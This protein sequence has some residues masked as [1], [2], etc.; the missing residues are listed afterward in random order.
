[1]R[2]QPPR[3]NVNDRSNIRNR[4]WF[5]TAINTSQASEL[6][7]SNAESYRDLTGPD[8]N[9]FR[10]LDSLVQLIGRVFHGELSDA[11]PHDGSAATI[12]SDRTDAVREL[13]PETEEIVKS[14]ALYGLA[15]RSS[16]Q[17]ISS[18]TERILQHA[19]ASTVS[20]SSSPIIKLFEK[21][22]KAQHT[23]IIKQLQA[24][25][26]THSCLLQAQAHADAL[27]G[28]ISK[29]EEMHQL[30]GEVAALYSQCLTIV[31]TWL[32]NE[33]KKAV[34]GGQPDTIL[35]NMVDENPKLS[36]ALEVAAIARTVLLQDYFTLF[37]CTIEPFITACIARGREGIS[38]SVLQHCENAMTSHIIAIH[39]SILGP[40][41]QRHWWQAQ[42]EAV[43]VMQT[44]L[45]ECAFDAAR[46]LSLSAR[47]LRP[48]DGSIDLEPFIETTRTSE[49][50]ESH[51]NLRTTWIDELQSMVPVRCMESLPTSV[52][53]R[54]NAG[55]GLVDTQ[56]WIS[57]MELM[58]HRIGLDRP[59]AG[60]SETESP[61]NEADL[62]APTAFVTLQLSQE[63]A[64]QRNGEASLQVQTSYPSQYLLV[65]SL[66]TIQG[67]FTRY[68]SHVNMAL[69]RRITLFPTQTGVQSGIYITQFWSSPVSYPTT[70][71]APHELESSEQPWFAQPLV[72]F[73][74][75]AVKKL[76]RK[77]MQFSRHLHAP[78]PQQR[79]EVEHLA[80]K[81]LFSH[82]STSAGV[83][84]DT[85]LSMCL[86][87]H[88]FGGIRMVCRGL[89]VWRKLGGFFERTTRRRQQL[90][91]RYGTADLR[92]MLMTGDKEGED[93]ELEEELAGYEELAASSADELQ[94][95]EQSKALMK[96]RKETN[97]LAKSIDITKVTS[98][99]DLR[100]Q[101][102][103]VF[104]A[105]MWENA[106]EV[107]PEFVAKV[108]AR[109]RL[110]RLFEERLLNL[111]SRS[112]NASG[113]EQG[114]NSNLRLTSNTL[115]MAVELLKRA[116]ASPSE[117]KVHATRIG[118]PS[119]IRVTSLADEAL[120]CATFRAACN[121]L[122]DL[123]EDEVK[124]ASEQS[125]R[126]HYS[127]A[128][129]ILGAAEI[130]ALEGR[131]DSAK[132]L[133]LTAAA[134]DRMPTS[135]AK[136]FARRLAEK[137][138]NL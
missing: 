107:T 55:A 138:F 8:A 48:F 75:P 127:A 116:A 29:R 86:T 6:Y 135:Q 59:N 112:D 88:A 99:E 132:S 79:C 24:V 43:Q 77:Q 13:P 16:L 62:Y 121:E 70:P 30:P 123:K 49:S 95:L 9:P 72:P 19:S 93:A 32:A 64:A 26:P 78:T 113:F 52:T 2:I 12:G 102:D 51:E 133:V 104:G 71:A 17:R 131:T 4:G 42:S 34:Q 50:S 10:A 76:S 89:L 91:A 82:S 125:T 31:K 129:F 35:V 128:D 103:E 41:T 60:D 18:L 137:E 124:S 45:L 57:V 47:L 84:L 21:P 136:E 33:T 94:G 37:S 85:F 36:D 39:E 28:M 20:S 117:T 73:Y 96:H 111:A 90:E 15:L 46:L 110:E 130:L 58:R 81:M 14:V 83:L 92:K 106:L 126:K 44:R 53:P 98:I 74:E 108:Q 105:S 54:K 97:T 61:T 114:F 38:E 23:E 87:G 67:W 65:H 40:S 109:D 118:L 25:V 122:M 115:H 11:S 100:Q 5:S 3:G 27:R 69:E 63:V 134:E 1:V 56:T 80:L 66:E 101:M 120:M 68:L 22:S 119:D 7:R